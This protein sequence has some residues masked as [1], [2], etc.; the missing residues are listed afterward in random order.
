MYI[1]AIGSWRLVNGQSS[2]IHIGA[3]SAAM[4]SASRDHLDWLR[5]ELA[6]TPHVVASSK[7]CIAESHEA[8]RLLARIQAEMRLPWIERESPLPN[9]VLPPT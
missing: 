5:R 3:S 7:Q 8:L 4:I 6:F 9:P 1:W 2:P